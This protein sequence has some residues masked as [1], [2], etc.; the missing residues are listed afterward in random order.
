[1]ERMK[2]K[3]EVLQLLDIDDCICHYVNCSR[4]FKNKRLTQSIMLYERRYIRV[5]VCMSN[6]VKSF[7]GVGRCI[8]IKFPQNQSDIKNSEISD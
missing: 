3:R 1:M 6:P 4:R 7:V 8:A 5:C 2:K